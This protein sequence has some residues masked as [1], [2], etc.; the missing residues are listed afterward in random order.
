M[1]LIVPADIYDS[2]TVV[3]KVDSF[4]ELMKVSA[5]SVDRVFTTLQECL[6]DAFVIDAKYLPSAHVINVDTNA[7][8]ITNICEYF[9]CCKVLATSAPLGANA[10]AK[11]VRANAPLTDP[12]RKSAACCCSSL[13]R[14]CVQE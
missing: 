4:A 2:Y 13:S 5:L 7:S 1:H 3:P 6:G 11:A 9:Q 10:A 14:T 12:R 8:L